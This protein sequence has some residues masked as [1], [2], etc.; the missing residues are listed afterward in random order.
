MRLR[1][2][3]R[4]PCLLVRAPPVGQSLMWRRAEWRRQIRP[5]RP[6]GRTSRVQEDLGGRGSTPERSGAQRWCSKDKHS[7]SPVAGLAVS[8]CG[9]T[10]TAPADAAPSACSEARRFRAGRPRRAPTRARAASTRPTDRP[11]A[12]APSSSRHTSQT[13]NPNFMVKAGD[14]ISTDPQIEACLEIGVGA[15]VLDRLLE[16]TVDVVGLNGGAQP[17]DKERFTVTSVLPRKHGTS[18]H[19]STFKCRPRSLATPSDYA[20]PSTHHRSASGGRG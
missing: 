18:S 8:G 19:V 1:R 10:A 17:V 7:N 12:H 5:A 6:A 2:L 13:R 16:L 3:H 15:D 9:R 11:Q 14:E 4:P 20:L